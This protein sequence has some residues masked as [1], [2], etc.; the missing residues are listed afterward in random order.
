MDVV[1]ELYRAI[2]FN[3]RNAESID[4]DHLE[5]I[6]MFTTTTRFA[7][8]RIP[9]RLF[10][11]ATGCKYFSGYFEIK[12]AF[13]I[14]KL[15]KGVEKFVADYYFGDWA[16]NLSEETCFI[17][18]FNQIEYENGK[19]LYESLSKEGYRLDVRGS[20]VVENQDNQSIDHIIVKRK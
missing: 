8:N 15:T 2:G 20:V 19:E 4:C 5:R 7:R 1:P 9:S 18:H 10:F 12:A 16:Y 3:I 6:R 11:K 13:K 14:A 17:G